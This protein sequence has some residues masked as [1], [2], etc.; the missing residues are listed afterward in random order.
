MQKLCFISSVCFLIQQGNLFHLYDKKLEKHYQAWGLV[1][2]NLLDF[3]KRC[4][5]KD[6]RNPLVVLAYCVHVLHYSDPHN[7]VSFVYLRGVCKRKENLFMW[8]HVVQHFTSIP[9]Y[10]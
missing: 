10:R 5:D 9:M 7:F 4:C 6:S 2:V 3:L 1:L 8:P